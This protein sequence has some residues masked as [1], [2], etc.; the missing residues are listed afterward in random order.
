MDGI[1]LKLTAVSLRD[2][3]KYSNQDNYRPFEKLCLGFI[4]MA[5]I[6]ERVQIYKAVIGNDRYLK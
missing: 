1:G 5:W 2:E 3:V 4:K 6:D